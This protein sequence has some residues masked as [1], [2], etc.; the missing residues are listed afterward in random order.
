MGNGGGEHVSRGRVGAQYGHARFRV[1]V[2]H[3]V[4]CQGA[5][6]GQEGSWIG[7]G[8]LELWE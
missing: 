6:W 3:V 4:G 7:S 8:V 1:H 5:G 2:R